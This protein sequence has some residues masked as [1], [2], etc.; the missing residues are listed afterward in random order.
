VS[1]RPAASETVM[2][3]PTEPTPNPAAGAPAAPAPSSLRELR[4]QI[5]QLDLQILELMNRRAGIA[6]QIGRVKNDRGEEVFSATREQE[7]LQNV[8]GVNRERGGP[9]SD[10][11]VQAVFRE[12]ISG[13]RAI[14]KVIKIAYLGPE[15]SFSHIAAVERFGQAVGL[16]PVDTITAVFEQVN[17]GH[18]DLGVVPLENSTDGRISD[19]L[20]MFAQL[21]HLPVCGEIRLAVHHNLLANCEPQDIRRVYSKSNALS[22]CRAWL[23]KNLPNAAL[24]ELASTSAAAEQ[25]Q[26][27]AGSAA[28]ASRQ[29]AV[30][31]GLRVLFSEIE[32]FPNNETRFAV[33]GR[34]RCG[35]TGNDKTAVMFR[36]PHSSGALVDALGVFKDAGINLTWIESFPARLPRPEYIFFVDF[37]GHADDVPVGQALAALAVHCHEVTVLGSF[38]AAA[39]VG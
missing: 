1:L 30:R 33:L 7:V 29:A 18:V 25:A 3:R 21:P 28:V 6:A 35:R 4:C 8:L 16:V 2:S 20:H 14:E 5:D 22:Q 31:Y 24:R 13:S 17:R 38:P 34:R 37:P 36:V 11:C 26:S 32:D 27:E 23:S 12:I 9:L 15:Y 10:A 39:P 19:T